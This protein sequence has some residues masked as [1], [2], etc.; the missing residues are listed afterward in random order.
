MSAIVVITTVGTEEQAILIARELVARRLAACVNV[1]ARHALGL[2]L[3]GQD[4]PRHR[5]PADRQD[6]RAASTRRSRPRS[7]SCTA[8]SCPRSSPSTSPSG[9]ERFLAWIGDTSTRPPRGRAGADDDGPRR[10][11]MPPRLRPRAARARSLTAAPAYTAARPRSRSASRS[12]QVLDP[13]R[14]PHQPVADA[15]LGALARRHRG[16]G[17]RR[18]V[19]DQRLDAA[20]ALGEAHH[21]EP[22][23]ASAWRRRSC[24]GRT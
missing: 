8:T 22:R 16:V 17:H 13:D 23:R 12:P 9:E 20:Q 14:D 15:E 2:P 18:R 19:R 4:L 5:V 1:R 6:A 11:R 21:L 7:R 24:R 10:R 3:A